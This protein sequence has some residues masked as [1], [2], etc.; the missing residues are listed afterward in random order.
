MDCIEISWQKQCQKATKSAKE[1][2]REPS[3]RHTS[4]R[5]GDMAVLGV[6]ESLKRL[7]AWERAS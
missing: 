4:T 2:I 1:D 7:P 6:A 3:G 5:E